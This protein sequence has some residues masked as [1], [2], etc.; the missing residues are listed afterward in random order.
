[1]ILVFMQYAHSVIFTLEDKIIYKTESYKSNYSEQFVIIHLK[2]VISPLCEWSSV[3]Y[4]MLN[5]SK[6]S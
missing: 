5:F 1:M 6:N 2:S 4:I 3:D